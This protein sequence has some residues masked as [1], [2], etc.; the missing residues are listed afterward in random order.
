MNHY[1]INPNQIL[2]YEIPVSDDP[3]NNM[4]QLGVDHP[5][6]FIPFQ[7][8]GCTIYF[9]TFVLSNDEVNCCPHIVLTDGEL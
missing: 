1:L 5:N 4:R 9:E 7:T 3:Y 6:L 8:E 2:H